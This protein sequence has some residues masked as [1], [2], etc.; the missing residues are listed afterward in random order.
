MIMISNFLFSF[1]S[2]CFLFSFFINLLTLG[3]LFS[4]AARA[5]LVAKL[6]LL[7]I[8]PLTSFVLA[9]GEALVTMLVISVFYRQYFLS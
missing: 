7:G 8:L 9:L 6:V 3:I 2:F 4:T 1:I 5:A